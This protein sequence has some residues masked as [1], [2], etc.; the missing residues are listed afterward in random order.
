[1]QV[2]SWDGG[3]VALWAIGRC[4]EG[5]E[6]CPVRVVVGFLPVL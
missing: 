4:L 5:P 3:E 1:M 2:C 6:E